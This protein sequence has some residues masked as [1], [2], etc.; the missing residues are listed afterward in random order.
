MKSKNLQQS[1][2]ELRIICELIARYGAKKRTGRRSN[3][4]SLRLTARNVPSL[5][6]P[7]DNSQNP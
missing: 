2:F 6:P 5:L 1:K 4:H 7:N 3:A